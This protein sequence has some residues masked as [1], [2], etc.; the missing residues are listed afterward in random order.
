MPLDVTELNRPPGL[1]AVPGEPDEPGA[2]TS[3]AVTVAANNRI[4]VRGR[5][6]ESEWKGDID[7]TGTLETPRLKGRLELIRGD[8]QFGGKVFEFEEG[9][10]DFYG[11]ETI[12]PVITA[13]AVYEVPNLTAEIAL[14]GPISEPSLSL[15][16][17]PELPDDEILARVMF[18]TTA[19]SL[20]AIEAAQ[21]AAAVASLTGGGGGFDV[22]GGIR[23]AL[24]LERLEIGTKGDEGNSPLIR[25]GK[26]LTDN[27]YVE[28]GTASGDDDDGA[29]AAIDIELTKNLTV[30]TEA[31][32]SGNQSIRVR[33]N[34]DY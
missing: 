31:T 23:K 12:D 30:G 29:A 14:L 33:W 5:G 16:S 18:G 32:T 11:G 6:L 34:W 19:D 13:R 9:L 7:V 26:Y 8:F 20:S 3:V 21:L 27:I 24:T 15:S 10:I 4:F 1:V 2:Q 17:R 28:V 22:V 25:G